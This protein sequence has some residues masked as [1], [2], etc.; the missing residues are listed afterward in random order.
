MTSSSR[1]VLRARRWA[2]FVLL[3]AV[4]LTAPLAQAPIARALGGDGPAPG[5]HDQGANWTT[6][7]K[8][9]LGTSAS[10][11]SNVWYTLSQGVLTDVFYP[12]LDSSNVQ[13][14]QLVVVD[15]GNK[16]ELERDATSHSVQVVDATALT[17]RQV[18]VKSGHYT[19]TKTYVTDPS[20]PTVYMN[21]QFDS[22]VAHGGDGASYRLYVLFNPSLGNSALHDAGTLD[23]ADG[24]FLASDV[25]HAGGPNF[26]SYLK[27]GG[28]SFSRMSNGFSATDESDG[29]RDLSKNGAL[30]HQFD[31][32]TDGN[33]VQTGQLSNGTSSLTVQL[34]LGFGASAAEAKT[35]TNT[36]L[37]MGFSAVESSYESGWH[38]YWTGLKGPPASVAG[39]T[40]LNQ[41][42]RTSVMILHASED[43]TNPGAQVAALATPWGDS[44]YD[45]AKEDSV[46]D[47]HAVWSRDAVQQATGLIAAGDTAQANRIVDFLFK[48]QQLPAGDFP[49]FS[50][51]SGVNIDPP[52][53]HQEDETALPIILAWQLN[54]TDLWNKVKSAAD[55]IRST[56]PGPTDRTERWEEQT[57]LSPS[58]IAAEIAAL[59]C[60]ADMASAL[61][62]ASSAA[63]YLNT[64]DAWR[65]DLQS[66]T[67]TNTGAQG[68]HSYY[69]RIENNDPSD[70]NHMNPNDTFARCSARGCMP[71]RDIVDG[72]ALE[73]VRL[74]VRKPSDAGVA[75]TI[76][77]LDSSIDSVVLGGNRYYYRYNKTLDAYG[78]DGSGTGF[79]EAKPG[80]GHPWPLLSG[81]RGEYELANGR[82]A[83]S[84]LQAMAAAAGDGAILSEQ[85]W[86]NADVPAKDLQQGKPTRSAGP[87]NWAAAEYV[88]LAASIDNGAPV[89]T[90]TVV[91]NRYVNP[92][93]HVTFTATVPDPGGRDVYLAGELTKLGGG[94]DWAPDGQKLT[95]IDA[96]H[97]SVTLSGVEDTSFQYKYTLGTWATVEKDGGCTEIR[98]NRSV[99][100]NFD[101]GGNQP[102]NDTVANWLSV[103]PC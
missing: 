63:S 59:V 23:S 56:G 3:A 93:V 66:W 33:V 60:A 30:T 46:R 78:E 4:T 22:T 48:R 41:L 103:A 44:K 75:D 92:T 35:N 57:G 31:S 68:D 70:P 40:K 76:D 69:E 10:G 18:N 65:R 50:F 12:T 96:T 49:R 47:Y 102:R 74:G 45:S 36:T 61:G 19:I 1:T 38:S 14:M 88:R 37:G 39:D 82:P 87:L 17:Y 6:G 98:R 20:R 15:T 32:A 2:L 101:I 8:Q 42:Y 67:F 80:A 7:H 13:D 28:V 99:T 9:G 58:S 97:Y 54:R 64:A 72:G 62:D 27:P 95:R 84:Q 90:P 79:P 52:A 21:V 89:E 5:A 71:E 51:T 77:E 100:L 85:I 91:K 43:K 11:A 53:A 94:S 86:E 34:A 26:Y 83:T 16:A 73:L 55:N 81:E 25:S 24:G 29:W